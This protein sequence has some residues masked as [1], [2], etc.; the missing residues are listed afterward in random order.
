MG[1]PSS[2]FLTTCVGLLFECLSVSAEVILE[3]GVVADLADVDLELILDG[4]DE[5]DPDVFGSLLAERA[6][7]AG[8]MADAGEF[9]G[10]WGGGDVEEFADQFVEVAYS[11][12][13]FGVVVVDGDVE[14]FFGADDEFHDVEA[15]SGMLA[16]VGS[17]FARMIP[18]MPSA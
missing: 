6:V 4:D 8:W 11:A 3:C 16:D 15:H 1:H 2:V 14:D 18:I 7:S 12:D 13:F 10:V 17:S 5:F 9:V